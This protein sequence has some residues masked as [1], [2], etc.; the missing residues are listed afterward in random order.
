M[1]VTFGKHRYEVTAV[2][3][4]DRESCRSDAVNILIVDTYELPFLE[5]FNSEDLESNYWT[6]ETKSEIEGDAFFFFLPSSFF[7]YVGF[8][9]QGLTFQSSGLGRPIDV[10]MTS[11]LLD[12]ANSE[13]VYLSFLYRRIMLSENIIHPPDVMTLEISVDNCETWTIVSEFPLDA[14]DSKWHLSN[15][16]VTEFV[17]GKMFNFRFK[18]TGSAHNITKMYIDL[19]FV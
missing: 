3:N 4:D 7:G 8:E 11:K 5:E 10:S 16:N 12:A 9:G 13:E 6:V 15:T 18:A 1:D 2:Y 17:S 14:T 19:S